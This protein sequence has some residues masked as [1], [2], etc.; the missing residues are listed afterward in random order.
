MSLVAPNIHACSDLGSEK[1]PP[2]EADLLAEFMGERFADGVLFAD[3]SAGSEHEWFEHRRWLTVAKNYRRY[4]RLLDASHWRELEPELQDLAI[5]STNQPKVRAQDVVAF[6]KLRNS[7]SWHAIVHDLDV[8]RND[9]SL[10]TLLRKHSFQV[11]DIQIADPYLDLSHPEAGYRWILDS[12]MATNGRRRRS[13]RFHVDVNTKNL[14]GSLDWI[15]SW[16]ATQDE[17]SRPFVSIAV[18]RDFHRRSLI[19]ERHVVDV[20]YGFGKAGASTP[21]KTMTTWSIRNGK[22][23]DRRRNEMDPRYTNRE[24]DWAIHSKTIEIT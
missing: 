18:W 24:S 7:K 3:L 11:E 14:A 13:L 1:L 4:N 20:E 8:Q 10:D 23:S 17:E 15:R 16:N 5:Y 2:T 9:G 22:A 21:G 12:V 19:T 6:P